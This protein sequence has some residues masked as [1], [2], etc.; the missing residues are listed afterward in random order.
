MSLNEV[1]RIQHNL[2]Q[3]L[4]ESGYLKGDRTGVGTLMLPGLVMD[5]DISDKKIPLPSTKEVFNKSWGF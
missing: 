4:M 3:T 2:Y 1:D 5:Y